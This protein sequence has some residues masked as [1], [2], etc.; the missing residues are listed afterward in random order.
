MFAMIFDAG[1][2]KHIINL[3][4]QPSF[5]WDREE[6]MIGIVRRHGVEEK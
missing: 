4:I 6:T 5:L 1:T 2:L 3:L